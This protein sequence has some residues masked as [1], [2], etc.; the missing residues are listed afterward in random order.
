MTPKEIIDRIQR[1]RDE[2]RDLEDKLVDVQRP[3]DTPSL[4]LYLQ[5]HPRV[6]RTHFDPAYGVEVL[7]FYG[8]NVFTGTFQFDVEGQPG[9]F[10]SMWL[11]GLLLFRS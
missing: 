1:L 9:R 5:R 6:R 10:C 8:N 2:I 3:T 11:T 4:R 7:R